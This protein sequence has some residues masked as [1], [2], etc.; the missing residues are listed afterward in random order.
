MADPHDNPE[1]AKAGDERA[2]K[3]DPHCMA[4]AGEAGGQDPA[5]SPT[6]QRHETETAGD[7]Q[8]GRK[9]HPPS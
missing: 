8:D 3:R 5:G 9:K 1:Q 2:Q 4:P 6:P 7:R